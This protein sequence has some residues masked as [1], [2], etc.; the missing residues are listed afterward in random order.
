[1][2]RIVREVHYICPVCG[3]RFED[4]ESAEKCSASHAGEVRSET[5]FVCADCGKHYKDYPSASGHFCYNSA[6]RG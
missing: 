5:F 4:R 6:L 3:D 2:S 1:M